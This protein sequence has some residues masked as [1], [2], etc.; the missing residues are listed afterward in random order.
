MDLSEDK[1]SYVQLCHENWRETW[2]PVGK[3]AL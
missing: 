1:G 3:L 2:Q